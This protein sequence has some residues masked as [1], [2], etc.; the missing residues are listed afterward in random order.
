MQGCVGACRC[1]PVC[2][3]ACRC[4]PV[5]AGACRCAVCT[6]PTRRPSPA[7]GADRSRSFRH[8][9]CLSNSSWWR[10]RLLDCHALRRVKHHLRIRRGVAAAAERAVARHAGGGQAGRPEDHLA[11]MARA[12]EGDL[13]HVPMRAQGALSWR[14]C[15]SRGVPRQRRPCIRSTFPHAVCTPHRRAA[16]RPLRGG[17]RAAFRRRWLERGAARRLPRERRLDLRCAQHRRLAAVH[18][19][20]PRRLV[21]GRPGARR[22]LLL[23]RVS[24]RRER[25]RPEQCGGRRRCTARPAGARRL[26]ARHGGQRAH[27]QTPNRT[28][29]GSTP[30]GRRRCVT[31]STF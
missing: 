6:A 27:L 15:G 16:G 9:C 19:H 4:V 3:N 30:G 24:L 23:R 10:R 5:C 25:R 22:T 18:R 8:W 20:Q 7:R 21:L 14:S 29:P 28:A 1:V 13:R 17:P 12:V 31:V 26:P 11:A 2:A